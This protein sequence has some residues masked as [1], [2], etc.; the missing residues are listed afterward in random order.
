MAKTNRNSERGAATR[1]QFLVVATRLFAEHGY[2]DTSI[3][4]V[5]QESGASR[6]SLYHHFKGKDSLFEAVLEAVE[7]D[8]GQ[9]TTAEA[10]GA[11]DAYQVLRAGCLAWIRLA[12]DPV[13][14]RIL[15]IDA[16]SV[17]GWQR[18]REMEE[19]HAL[20]M[21]KAVVGEIARTGRLTPDLVD[22]FAHMLLAS[23]NEI[24]LFI[25]RA[26]DP[27]AA[28]Q[29]GTAAIEELLHRL[30]GPG[31]QQDNDQKPASMSTL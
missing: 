27:A 6:G 25:A 13:V 20:G 16:P 29:S 18:W 19:R 2:D 23:I 15:L 1:E 14:Q 8:V 21:I 17:L 10:A 12:G 4:A 5:L 24:A 30:L 11:A 9:R 28:M 31:S 7:T 22:M 3:E 26:D